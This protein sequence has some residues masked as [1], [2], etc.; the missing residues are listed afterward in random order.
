MGVAG[1]LGMGVIQRTYEFLD[2]RLTLEPLVEY[3]RHKEVPRHRFSWAYFFGGLTLFFFIVQVCSGILLL[4]YYRP[5]AEAAFDSVQFIMTRVR[6]GWLVRSIHSWSANLMILAAFVH[7]FSVFLMKSY[8][9][10]REVTWW[11]GCILLALSMGF[12]FSGYL[13]PWNV[14]AFFAT[15]VGTE[16]VH[17]VPVIGG[18]L[19]RFLRGGDEVTG[20]TLT[21]FFGFH[22]AVLP[23][24]TAAFLVAHLLFIQRQGMHVPVSARAESR[25]RPAMRFVPNFMLRELLVWLI[26]LALLAALAAFFPWELGQK[27]DPF[28]SAPAG[29]KPEWYFLFMFE[30]LKLLPAYILGM[31]GELFGLTA[32][33]LAAL[34][35]FLVPV[36]DRRARQGKRSPLFTLIGWL[37][38]LYICGMTLFSMSGGL[39]K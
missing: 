18:W 31:E 15:H 34:L 1:G 29:I 21:R 13:L 38:I 23:M 27:A 19:L 26:G 8:A 22:V 36:L 9:R 28:A 24:V 3:L 7:M 14:L 33:G 17:Q 6:F 11:T 16:M 10:P 25:R 35:W 20:A 39:S 30:T 4:L 37:A 2:E 5:T 32:F 12:G